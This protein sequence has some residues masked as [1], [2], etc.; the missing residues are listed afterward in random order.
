M[1]NKNNSKIFILVIAD[2]EEVRDGI[3]KLLKTDGY[4]VEAARNEEEACIR[5]MHQPPDVI[6]V[7][8]NGATEAAIQT[9]R[10]IRHEAGLLE[11]KVPIVLFCIESIPQGEEVAIGH[12]VYLTQL[13]NFNQLRA[14]LLRLL[15]QPT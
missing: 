13:N 5:A 2:V 11:E 3:E 6:V 4:R 12:N 9:A 15:A 1:N 10:R 14:F 8:L 7:S